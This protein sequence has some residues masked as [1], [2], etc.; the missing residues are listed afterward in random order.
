MST[1]TMN[2]MLKI[3][4]PA[5]TPASKWLQKIIFR[6]VMSHL[7]KAPEQ[8]VIAIGKLHHCAVIRERLVHFVDRHIEIEQQGALAVMAH[9]TLHPKKGCEPDAAGDR[10]YMVQAASR[11]NHHV[12]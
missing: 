9:H 10:R 2:N 7:G 11:I 6:N 1:T 4:K 3:T 8:V 12:T 5:V